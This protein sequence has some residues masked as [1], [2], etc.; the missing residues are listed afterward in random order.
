MT[1]LLLLSLAL[2]SL[3]FPSAS[4]YLEFLAPVNLTGTKYDGMTI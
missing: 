3:S 1:N 2:L 4:A